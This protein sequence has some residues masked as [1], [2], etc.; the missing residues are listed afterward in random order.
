[1]FETQRVD[2]LNSKNFKEKGQGI[3]KKLF[4]CLF[5]CSFFSSLAGLFAYSI[6][7]TSNK[8][9]QDSNKHALQTIEYVLQISNEKEVLQLV[10]NEITNSI[11]LGKFE[12]L[13]EQLD[14]LI[15]KTQAFKVDFVAQ[16]SQYPE[17]KQNVSAMQAKLLQLQ[18]ELSDFNESSKE[19][20]VTHTGLRKAGSELLVGTEIMATQNYLEQLQQAQ[21]KSGST[22]LQLQ[23]YHSF[24]LTLSSLLD[25]F[26]TTLST[27][28]YFDFQ[29][30]LILIQSTEKQLIST[31]ARFPADD[32]S[33]LAPGLQIMNHLLYKTEYFQIIKEQTDRQQN[34]STIVQQGILHLTA[35][36]AVLAKVTQNQRMTLD[37]SQNSLQLKHKY[38]AYSIA[39]FSLLALLLPL[40]FV[41]FYINPILIRRLDNLQKTTERI[42]NEEFDIEIDTSGTD[43]LSYL[44]RTLD[45]F[46]NQLIEK[47]SSEAELK[48][49]KAKAEDKIIFLNMLMNNLPLMVAVKNVN[50]HFIQA[51][52]SWDYFFKQYELPVSATEN[53]LMI[54]GQ[55]LELGQQ[56]YQQKFTS[57]KMA[58][59]ERILTITKIYFQDVH[60]KK[61]ILCLGQ[62]VTDKERL[63]ENLTQS[64]AELERFSFVASHDLQEPLRSL[65]IFSKKVQKILLNTQDKKT[66][67]YLDIIISSAERMQT[68]V[69]D[70][71]EYTKLGQDKISF[72]S[73]DLNNSFKLA[74]EALTGLIIERG[75]T[76]TLKKKLPTVFAVQVN[77]LSVFQHLLS[78]SLIYCA[79]NRPVEIQVDVAETEHY[80]EISVQDNGVG[81]D[82]RFIDNIFQPFMRLH[83]QGQFSGTGLGLTTVQKILQM[84]SGFIY[85][86]S[87]LDQGSRFVVKLP[88]TNPNR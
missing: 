38:Y 23:N 76:I 67:Q 31:F 56:V 43:E 85:V 60:G 37:K 78:N 62:D 44:A 51:N 69:Q 18:Q 65:Q 32:R 49:T 33:R 6:F 83:T 86:T 53:L 28:D 34:M 82:A 79:E 14:Q 16:F 22:Q 40:A 7:T 61:L 3:S 87:V 1:M 35:T 48:K 55:A 10:L 54:D 5:V 12:S 26:P 70:L 11:A 73:V 36:A 29:S 71:L 84:H 19:V 52:Y 63:I 74:K 9:Y 58:T 30:T 20:L 17:L 47:K 27:L 66:S 13:P 57:K 68:L 81:I 77:M 39:L 64:N 80:W 2:T 8:A 24:D 41:Y 45:R 42:A 15:L 21:K 4:Y 46:R 50:G 75:A 59:K 25:F 88:K 72:T